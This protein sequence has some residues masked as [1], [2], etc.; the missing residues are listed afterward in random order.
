MKKIGK[1]KALAV[2]SWI[3]TALVAIVIFK[4]SCDTAEESA[5]ISENLLDIIIEFIGNLIGH[6]A[7]RE[8]AHFC[9]FAALGFFMAGSFKFTWDKLKFYL[10]LIPCALYAASDEIH[11]IFVP[12][13]AFEVFDISIDSC[14]SLTGILV[15]ILLS[16]IIEKIMNRKKA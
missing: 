9:E 16:F 10:P 6:E 8:F 2:V 12:G 11:Q 15:F 7:F 3:F 1:N 5:E 13:R 4:F 14:G